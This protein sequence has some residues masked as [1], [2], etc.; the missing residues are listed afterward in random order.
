MA[1]NSG[2]KESYNTCGCYNLFEIFVTELNDFFLLVTEAAMCDDKLSPNNFF[3]EIQGNLT[4][5][6]WAHAVN[7]KALLNNAL[8]DGK[9]LRILFVFV[10]TSRV[11]GK[12]SRKMNAYHSVLTNNLLKRVFPRSVSIFRL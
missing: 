6:V 12:S 11:T 3:P 7:S 5:I 10:E 9:S 2:L 1:F 8:K 4:K